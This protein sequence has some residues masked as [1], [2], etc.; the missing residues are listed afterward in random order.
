METALGS[1]ILKNAASMPGALSDKDMKFLLTLSG[2][3]SKSHDARLQLLEDAKD[4][5]N[6]EI[7]RSRRQ[8][9]DVV[10]GLYREKTST[11]GTE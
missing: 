7:A 1:N 6:R 10:A 11:G 4:R 5:L 3:A 8:Y 2:I 9:S